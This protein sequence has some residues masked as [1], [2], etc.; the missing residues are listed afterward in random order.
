MSA[1]G[2]SPPWTQ[3]SVRDV[4]VGPV[5]ALP[6]DP[7]KVAAMCAWLLAHPTFDLPALELR[8]KP[9]GTFRV[10]DGRHRFLAYVLAQRETVPGIVRPP[11][12]Q[13]SISGGR[14]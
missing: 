1:T 13:R 4:T 6:G 7:R 14:P 12:T 9:N 11:A 10:H 5:H 8:P 3:V 2:W